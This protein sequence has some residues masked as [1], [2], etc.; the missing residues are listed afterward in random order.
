MG[1]VAR[2]SFAEAPQGAPASQSPAAETVKE[3]PAVHAQGPAS[4]PA[5]SSA[6]SAEPDAITR[7]AIAPAPADNASPE[8]KIAG[9]PAAADGKEDDP[10]Q[11]ALASP[12]PARHLSPEQL[13]AFRIHG[14]TP[15]FVEGIAS[16]GYTRI[17]P[18]TLLALRI[19]DVTLEFLSGLRDL[20]GRLP[21]EKCVQLQKREIHLRF[22]KTPR[23][24]W[25]CNR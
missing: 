20:F 2:F 1:A 15:E 23:A 16:L 4:G 11:P 7:P 25:P 19:H 22:P 5:A 10:T 17:S 21:L 6:T 24:E 3:T 14:V 9:V 12:R 13:I 18:D 8:P